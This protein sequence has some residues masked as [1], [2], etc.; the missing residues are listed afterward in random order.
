MTSLPAIIIFIVS[1]LLFSNELFAQKEIKLVSK[2][3]YEKAE[4]Y[5][6]SLES[7]EEQIKCL[8][9]IADR[10]FYYHNYDKAVEFYVKAGKSELGYQKMGDLYFD[11]K[12]YKEAIEYYEKAFSDDTAKLNKH[13]TKIADLY[14]E[15]NYI[16][17]ARKY[18]NKAGNMRG[19]EKIGDYYYSSASEYFDKTATAQTKNY[20]NAIN[21]Y[22]TAIFYYEQAFS[23][24]LH[25]KIKKCNGKIAD[26]WFDRGE[27]WRCD[28]FYD[29]AEDKKGL[30]KLGD[31][32]LAKRDYTKATKFYK[33]AFEGNNEKLNESYN[34]IADAYFE[35]KEYV[36]AAEYYA[37]A[38]LKEEEEKCYSFFY[39]KFKDSRDGKTYK[40]IKIG[41][42]IWMAENL[43]YNT[44]GG[45]WAYDNYQRNVSEYGYLYDWETAKKVCP[46]GWHLPSRDEF[47][48]LLNNYGEGNKYN[49]KN[50]RA[51]VY[52]KI[53]LKVLFA[54]ERNHRG[55]FEDIGKLGYFWTS[56]W[57]DHYDDVNVA[58][59]IQIRKQFE[60]AGIA[61][62][63]DTDCGK[64]IRC[65]KD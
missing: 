1:F 42:Q 34:K 60:D 45:C 18:Y 29:R 38:G 27:I 12:K 40:Y 53:G 26:I 44:Y 4:E 17:L 48:T 47:V 5:C 22:K 32:Y 15:L 54:G 50:Y 41:N 2:G 16:E 11:Q 51:L 52:D 49:K 46:D 37:K 24:K 28:Y 3:K 14:F 6:R 64:S 57:Y 36:K 35:K 56:T 58:Y 33:K 7:E 31:Y 19:I 13:Y 8:T 43:A 61:T 59:G 10:L 25:E 63:T 39:I 65:V 55:E 9:N 62:N 30:E 20:I 23:D 21:R